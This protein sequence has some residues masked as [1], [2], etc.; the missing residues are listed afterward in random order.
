MYP[1]V[2]PSGP[3]LMNV[4]MVDRLKSFKRPG[5]FDATNLGAAFF[6]SA[7]CC[8]L[9]SLS[10][11]LSPHFFFL[12]SLSSLSSYSPNNKHPTTNRQ[13]AIHNKQQTTHNSNHT[14]R[15][16]QQLTNNTQQ[17]QPITDNIPPPTP[18]SGPSTY[19]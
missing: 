18:N 6:L 7:L 11:L 5:D 9:S 10:S 19:N 4:S 16:T 3:D 15:N 1:N 2:A 17:Q 14:T 12:P 8:L 13:Q